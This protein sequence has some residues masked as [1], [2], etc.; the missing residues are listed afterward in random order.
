M[1]DAHSMVN[2]GGRHECGRAYASFSRLARLVRIPRR[3]TGRFS[4]SACQ[5]LGLSLTIMTILTNVGDDPS[6]PRT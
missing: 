4:H 1:T 3:P 5:D 2:A 6:S